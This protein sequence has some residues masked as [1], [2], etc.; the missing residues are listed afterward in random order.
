MS[1][2]TIEK[3]VYAVVASVYRAH[4]FASCSDGFA[5]FTYHNIFI[6][7]IDPLAIKPDIDMALNGKVI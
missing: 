6:F 1:W 4:W 5:L 7:I 3:E 2:S